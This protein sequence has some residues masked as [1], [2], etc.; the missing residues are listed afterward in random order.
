GASRQ[1]DSPTGEGRVP[2]QRR[3]GGDRVLRPRREAP[4]APSR[5][6]GEAG[7]G[8][9]RSQQDD[10]R[11][12]IAVNGSSSDKGVAERSM[13][14]AL[15]ALNWFAVSDLLDRIRMRKQVE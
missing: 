9:D 15:R 5:R 14:F 12:E 10:Q 7:R 11:E 3:G 1:A 4:H 6:H 2:Q 8:Q 13:G